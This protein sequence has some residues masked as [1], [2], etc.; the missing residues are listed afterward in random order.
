MPPILTKEIGK[1]VFSILLLKAIGSDTIFALV[2]Q[3]LLPIIKGVVSHLFTISV[4]LEIMPDQYKTAEIISLKKLQKEDYTLPSAYWPI[5]LLA[6][7]NKMMKS[8]I[9]QRLACMAKEYSLL[10]YNNFRD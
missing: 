8:V 6:T 7:L 10:L 3:K 1:A 4:Q 2:W 5:S 9:I